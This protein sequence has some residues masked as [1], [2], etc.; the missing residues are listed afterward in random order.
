MP[1]AIAV[2][3]NR[4]RVLSYALARN[5][6]LLALALLLLQRSGAV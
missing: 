3:L 6:A 5:A 2:N 1:G 4:D